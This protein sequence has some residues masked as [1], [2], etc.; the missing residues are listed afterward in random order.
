MK[1]QIAA[2]FSIPAS[3]NDPSAILGN[4]VVYS[5]RYEKNSIFFKT[6][7]VEVHSEA[8]HNWCNRSYSARFWRMQGSL[9]QLQK[10][11][12]KKLRHYRE[13][14]LMVYINQYPVAFTEIYQVKKNILGRYI[15]AGD[16]D[17]GLHLLLAPYKSLAEQLGTLSKGFS[18]NILTEILH[19][20]FLHSGVKRVVAEPDK[21][22]VNACSLA[23]RAGFTFLGEIELPDKIA[24]IYEYTRA[25]FF[26]HRKPGQ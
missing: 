9:K 15:P 10:Y 2:L 24:N 25:D 6:F 13:V 21:N 16:N 18:E 14:L 7:S 5:C 1:K 20:L 12:I 11:Y 19:Y 8:L 3:A 17:Y 26:K 23:E 4:H 22:N